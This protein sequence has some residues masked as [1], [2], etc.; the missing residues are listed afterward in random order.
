M[1]MNQISH[2]DEIDL[3][4]LIQTL[5]EGKWKIISTTFI[6]AIMG[7]A[8]S[9]V[10]SSSF[11][12]F[13][14]IQ[15]GKS[16]V[17]VGYTSLNDVLKANELPLLVDSENVFQLFVFEFNDY[18]EMI[19]VLQTNEFVTRSIKKLNDKDRDLALI[20]YAKS[21]TIAPPS[22]NETNWML[23]FEWH[24]VEEG[25][26]LLNEA[27]N[28]TLENVKASIFN[29]IAKLADAVDLRNQHELEVL[30]TTLDFLEKR[31]LLATEKRIL[32]LTEQSAIA[33]ELG[34]ETNRLDSSDLTQSQPSSLSLNIS[35]YE[36]PYYLRGF[37][38][39]DK[40][41]ALIR[42]RSKEQQLIMA[43]QYVEIKGK[44]YSLEN[45]LS[46]K[47]LR[48]S[49]ITLE[50]DTPDDWVAF[51]LTL[52]DNVSQRN[53]ILYVALSTVLGGMMGVMYVLMSNAIHKRR[54]QL[55]ET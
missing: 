38:A 25:S 45:D 9:L 17:F 53:S 52:A 13:T 18:E 6:A 23:S 28:I 54:E 29:D 14:P 19:S 10:I 2:D 3:I 55:P 20:E 7:V 43:D 36:I 26:N 32:Y 12:V 22:K 15:N 39:I 40:E 1:K 21:F 42:S 11:K 30:H 51:D 16:S 49:L 50:S 41:I 44:I 5:W 24:D 34:V 37:K 35:S 4:A 8:F 31:N 46:S 48:N 47:H 27:L 33:R